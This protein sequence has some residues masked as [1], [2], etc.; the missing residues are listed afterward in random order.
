MSINFTGKQTLK[1]AMHYQL[2]QNLEK[3]LGD[4]QSLMVSL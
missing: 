3:I 1:F 4:L 2:P